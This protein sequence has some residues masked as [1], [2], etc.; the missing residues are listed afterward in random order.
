MQNIL[1]KIHISNYTYLFFL[2]AFISG[3][4]KNII[5]IFFICII[6]ELG[7]VVFIK[8]FKYKIN[9]IEILPFGGFTSIDKKI[10]TSIFKDF[11]IAIGGIVAQLLLGIIIYPL[12][13]NINIITYNLFNY[14]NKLLIIFNLLPIIPLDG[15]KIVNLI[16]EKYYSYKLSYYINGVISIISLVLF[17]I[18]NYIYNLD[19]YFIILFLLFK[20]IM[21]IKEYKHIINRFLLERYLY[22]LEYKHIN[23]KTERIEE[24][25]KETYHYFNCDGKIITEK[26]KLREMFDKDCNMR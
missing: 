20:F 8:L 16:L 4:I 2:L 13:D 5:I 21:Y 3:Y 7:H 15:S 22:N 12:K 6:H 14:Y 18:I 17:L 26:A 23:C 19:N 11:F 9:Y 24:I 10:N 1:N 25:K